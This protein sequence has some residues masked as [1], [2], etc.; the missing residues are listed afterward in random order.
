MRNK[1]E[2][3][4]IYF[5][6]VPMGGFLMEKFDIYKDIAKRTGGDVYIGVVGPVRTGKSTFI[7]RFT[8]LIVAPNIQ[9]KNK[10]QI[11]VDEMPLS[12]VG[13]TITTTEPKFVPSEAVKIALKGKSYA[14]VRLID[15]VGF[16]VDGAIGDKENDAP[17]LVKTP[18]NK[19]PVP[20]ETAAEIGTDKVISEHSTVAV[21]V[22]TDGSVCD[23]ERK[24]YIKAEEK[25]VEKLVNCGKPFVIVLNSKNPDSKECKSLCEEL[26]NKYGTAVLP[27][28]LLNA[29]AE[30]LTEV[31]ENILF[32]FPVRTFDIDL[33]KW[34]QV[35]PPESKLISNI[36]NS[37]KEISPLIEKMKHRNLL[38]DGLTQLDG[39]K[40]VK[41]K[42][43]ELGE[44]K[45]VFQVEPDK[46]VFYN[47]L[48]ELAG[49]EITDEY[50][51]TS[52][53]KELT[54]A[55]NNYRKLKTA[56][57]EVDDG[58]YGIV[59]PNDSEM[60]LKDPE[61][62]RSG[63]RYGVKL[64]AGSNC[65]HLIKINLDAEV[66][67]IYGTKQQCV[68]YAEFIKNEY[69]LDPEKVWNLSVFGKPLSKIIS[70]ELTNKISA[71]KNE[72]K[73]KMQKTVTKIVNDGK[74]GILFVLL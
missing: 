26:K 24:N 12:G 74:G 53:I 35:L 41:E 51:L 52:Y 38:T 61:V 59:V 23:I 10:R 44:G 46:N 65:M 67:P 62:I 49:E 36:I 32:E 48:S 6:K 1:I 73:L 16:M 63:G 68:D 27:L 14:M 72:T 2:N 20:F 28:D 8:D 33:P 18:W 13:K 50:K 30:D 3:P 55:K 4:L 43:A 34:M 25:A 47:L 64:K 39:I 29:S 31:I 69:Q 21:L 54:H 70:S 37:V 71:M 7:T 5:N 19:E 17:R 11:A 58:G 9:N 57:T 42:N 45:T 66:T 22:T 15:C 56:L 60:V 40:S